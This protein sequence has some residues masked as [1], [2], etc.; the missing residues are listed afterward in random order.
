MLLLEMMTGLLLLQGI[1]FIL[2]FV[3][4]LQIFL[5]SNH[6]QVFEE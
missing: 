4:D 5:Q 6:S 1:V 3:E 2:C